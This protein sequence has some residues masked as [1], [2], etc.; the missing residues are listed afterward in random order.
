MKTFGGWSGFLIVLALFLGNE[1]LCTR[2]DALY[3]VFPFTRLL[4]IPAACLVHMFCTFA[5][6][7]RFSEL[8]P[9]ATSALVLAYQFLGPPL[10]TLGV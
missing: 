5:T 3:L 4:I 2:G 9:V 1:L 10:R 6:T 7:T 8:I